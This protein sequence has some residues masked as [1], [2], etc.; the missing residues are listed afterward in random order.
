MMTAMITTPADVSSNTYACVYNVAEAAKKL[1]VSER[2]I[3]KT[4]K[5]LGVKKIAGRGV[6]GFVKFDVH[7]I[8]VVL[9]FSA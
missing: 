9:P 4:A 5:Q 6:A 3:R 8:N 2:M 1:G 7:P